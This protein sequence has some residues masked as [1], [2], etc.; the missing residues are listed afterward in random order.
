MLKLGYKASSEQFGPTEL[1]DYA[2]LAEECG[3]DSVWI[4]DHF[5][6]W[7]HTHGHAP[8]SLAWPTTGGRCCSR[9]CPMA[10]S[11]T[12]TRRP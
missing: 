11:P 3:Y 2:R 5:Q 9:A 6:P 7:R 8:F 4:S 12:R 1:L 10:S